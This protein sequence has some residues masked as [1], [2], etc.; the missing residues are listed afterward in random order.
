MQKLLQKLDNPYPRLIDNNKHNSN[1]Y[2]ENLDTT[3]C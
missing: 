3:I 1:C 2:Y